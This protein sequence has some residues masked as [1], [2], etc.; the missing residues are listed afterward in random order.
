VALGGVAAGAGGAGTTLPAS[1]ATPKVCDQYTGVPAAPTPVARYSGRS[2]FARCSG[3]LS[4]PST[5][6]CAVAYPEARSSPH[7]ASG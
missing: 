5:T 1:I 6:A 2:M 4:Q 3:E 7:S